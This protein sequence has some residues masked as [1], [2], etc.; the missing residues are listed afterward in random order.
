MLMRPHKKPWKN[1]LTCKS[2]PQYI[3]IGLNRNTSDPNTH[4]NRKLALK[5]TRLGWVVHTQIDPISPNSH[6]VHRVE[7]TA[8]IITWP[9]GSSTQNDT[10]VVPPPHCPILLPITL[11]QQIVK[12]PTMLCLTTYYI[13]HRRSMKKFYRRPKA[14]IQLRPHLIQDYIRISMFSLK[15]K[16]TMQL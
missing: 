9:Y 1:D 16:W 3:H 7:Q 6:S 14:T 13:R 12:D 4:L 15:S 5:G 2:A 8:L 11:W 10:L